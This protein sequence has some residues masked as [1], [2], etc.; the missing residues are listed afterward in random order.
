VFAAAP[1][2][3]VAVALGSPAVASDRSSALV[4]DAPP[5]ATCR[6]GWTSPAPGSPEYEQGLGV[7]AGYF[8]ISGG[9]EVAEIRYFTGPDAPGVIEPRFDPV[10]RWYLEV[11]QVDDPAW[12]GRFIVEWRT[13]L[14][15][16]V[17]A[18]APYD[19]TGY[20][21]PDWRAFEGEGEF[22][23]VDGLPGMWAGL[24][25]DFVSGA[26][27]SGNRGLPPEVEGCLAAV[28][29]PTR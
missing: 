14:I 9:I 29:P 25:Y 16:G 15:N 12:R 18:V 23:P 20:Q 5:S 21:S 6:D 1:L 8:G 28:L 24:E 19:T 11:A 27:G 3:V 7:L 2:L 4:A 10:L 13:D 26:G 22:R 17:S